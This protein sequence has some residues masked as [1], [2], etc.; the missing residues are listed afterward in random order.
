MKHIVTLIR[1]FFLLLF[2]FLVINGKMMLWLALFGSGLIAAVLFGRVYC[3]YACPMNTIMIPTAWLSKKLAWQT[4]TS[5]EWI[6][7]EKCGWFSLIGSRVL[8]LSARRVLDRNLPILLIWLVAALLTTLR[9]KPSVFHNQ[10]CPFGVLQKA[11]GRFALISKKVKKEGC[12]GCTLCEKVCPSNAIIVEKEEKK[13][14]INKEYCFQCT[15]CQ[16]I[17]PAR[18]IQYTK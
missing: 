16:Q 4:D 7:S 12:I 9:Y 11:F 8:M 5:P 6:S 10:I 18:S 15:N 17:C 14:E 13:A 1:V 2:L 3:G